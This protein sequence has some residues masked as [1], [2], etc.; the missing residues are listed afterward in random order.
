[1]IAARPRNAIAEAYVAA[2][3]LEVRTLKPGNVHIFADG[4]RMTVADFDLSATVS[5]PF[6]ADPALSVG[7]RI[8]KAVEATFAAVATNTNLGIV[9]LCA[10]LAAAAEHGTESTSLADSLHAVLAALDHNDARAAYKAIAMANPAG[11]G[12]D[13]AGDVR[14]E[15]P[16]D[17]TLLDAMRAAAPRDMIAQEYATGFATIL[18][19]A[20][21]LTEDIASGAAPEDALAALFLRRLSERPDTHI[22]RKHGP[23]LAHRVMARAAETVA[24]LELKFASEIAKR[25]N[26]VTLL[27]LDAEL[28]SWGANPGSLADL[29]CASAFAAMLVNAIGDCITAEPKNPN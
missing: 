21:T 17:W 24:T 20:R 7:D 8:F 9:L 23:A 11:L 26:R 3:R 6:I 13:D 14:A 12:S 10:P 4:H 18:A 15:P 16:A 25:E 5:A 19:N 2:C 29:M 22:V 28:K 1:M 27:D